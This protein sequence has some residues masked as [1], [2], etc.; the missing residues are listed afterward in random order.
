MTG[1]LAPA[2]A[3]RSGVRSACK[4]KACSKHERPPHEP[5]QLAAACCWSSVSNGSE[6]RTRLGVS[7]RRVKLLKGIRV[8]NDIGVDW[9]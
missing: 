9:S 7:H 5:W 3:M 8:G 6:G 4:L 1:L 2:G